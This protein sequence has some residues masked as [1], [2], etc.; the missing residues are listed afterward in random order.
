MVAGT[1]HSISHPSLPALESSP[2]AH[3]SKY[4]SL[5]APTPIGCRPSALPSAAAAASLSSEIGSLPSA[6]RS[7]HTRS[8]L[9]PIPVLR[10]SSPVRHSRKSIASPPFPD[11]PPP[12]THPTALPPPPLSPPPPPLAP[13][14]AGRGTGS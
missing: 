8:E 3:T 1:S 6:R 13:G 11:S 9:G 2:L 12:S 14:M 5:S 4:S 10:H 7:L